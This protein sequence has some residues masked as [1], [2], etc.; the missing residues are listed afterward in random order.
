M[1]CK[2]LIDDAYLSTLVNQQR[3]N[4]IRL[5]PSD[6]ANRVGVHQSAFIPQVV[7]ATWQFKR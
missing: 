2:A 6:L 4:A 7:Y 1:Q 3:R 5:R